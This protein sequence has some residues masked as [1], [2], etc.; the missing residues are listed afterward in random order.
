VKG[1]L[2]KCDLGRQREDRILVAEED[3]PHEIENHQVLGVLQI[4]W[5]FLVCSLASP[6]SARLTSILHP[7]SSG[8]KTRG[9]TFGVSFYAF[10][11]NCSLFTWLFNL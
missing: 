11:H 6:K 4:N 2:N 7:T 10:I 8:T 1:F 3:I 5:E 9:F